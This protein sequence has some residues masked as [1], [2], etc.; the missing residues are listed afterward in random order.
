MAEKPETR[1]RK[2]VV[3]DL[4]DLPATVV[5]SI[6]QRTIQG[7]PDLMICMRGFFIGLELKSAYGKASKL[8]EYKLDKI[9]KAHGLAFVVFPDNWN[10]IL[11]NLTR[12][13]RGTG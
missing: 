10:E 4:R 7:D 6:Q 5:F 9:R 8:Q 13:A 2:K 12:L 3:E 11:T 1:F